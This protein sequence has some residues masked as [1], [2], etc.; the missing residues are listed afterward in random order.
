MQMAE[1]LEIGQSV[2]HVAYTRHQHE[3][4]VAKYLAR[5]GLDVFHPV[6]REVRQWK[7]RKK[8]LELPLFPG[9]VFFAGGMDRRVDILSAPGLHTILY[10]GNEAAIVPAEEIEAIRRAGHETGALAPHPFATEG[11]TVRVRSGPLEGVQGILEQKKGHCRLVLRIAI[12]GRAAAVEVDANNI[13]R[14]SSPRIVPTADRH[15]A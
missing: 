15:A 6:Y 14:L 8:E 2:W 9:Y 1:K 12:L 3:R 4:S 13:E 10:I 11:E 5:I 7:D